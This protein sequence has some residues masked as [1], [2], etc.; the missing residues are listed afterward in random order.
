MTY[1]VLRMGTGNEAKL[2]V[3]LQLCCSIREAR[4]SKHQR[5]IS[6]QQKGT[7]LHMYLLDLT[8]TCKAFVRKFSVRSVS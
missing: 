8:G 1:R 5:P 6:H 7:C 2:V 3:Y 4:V